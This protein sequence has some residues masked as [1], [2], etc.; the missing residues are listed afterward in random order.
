MALSGIQLRSN[1]YASM[2]YTAP[3]GG[4]T[5]GGMG[6]IGD[7]V[8]VYYETKAAGLTV[9]AVYKANKIL[10]TKKDGSGEAIAQGAK[11]YYEA[12][13]GKVTAVAGSNTMCGRALEAAGADD[14]T[15]LV[16]FNGHV[17]A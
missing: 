8:V 16:A 14:T 2:T 12:A 3:S 5:A 9:A 11:V 7:T 17:A 10:L 4:V 6:K 13:S 15:V 1:V